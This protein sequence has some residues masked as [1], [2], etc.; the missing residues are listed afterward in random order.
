MSYYIESVIFFMFL[1][2]RIE[3]SQITTIDFIKKKQIQMC[4]WKNLFKKIILIEE[5]D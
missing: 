4:V 1:D 5:R 3:D 2:V